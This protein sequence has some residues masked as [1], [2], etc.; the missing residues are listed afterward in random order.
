MI[1]LPILIIIVIATPFVLKNID[2]EN[3]TLIWASSDNFSIEN[4]GEKITL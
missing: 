4:N 3:N 1:A 2:V